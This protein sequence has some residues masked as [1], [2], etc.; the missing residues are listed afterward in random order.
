VA[1]RREHW[2]RGYA[3]EAIRLILRYYFDELRY[4][5]ANVEI[6]AFN[7][8]SLALHRKLGFQEEGRLRRTVYTEG[9]YFDQV[10]LGITGEE[11]RQSRGKGR[12]AVAPAD[13]PAS[14]STSTRTPRSDSG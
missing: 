5:M 8:A 13:E 2:R 11:F 7:E 3:A 10:I 1:I 6:H 4:Q 12:P 14:I 9:K